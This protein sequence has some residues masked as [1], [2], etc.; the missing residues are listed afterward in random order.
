[1]KVNDILRKGEIALRVLLMKDDLCFCIN[2]NSNFMPVWMP[3]STLNEYTPDTAPMIDTNMTTKQKQVAHERYTMIA[4]MLALI[5]DEESDPIDGS[6]VND[7]MER[8]SQET[9]ALL[10]HTDKQT[11]MK[12]TQALLPEGTYQ[13]IF[14]VPDAYDCLRECWKKAKEACITAELTKDD[15][16]WYRLY[17]EVN[18][19]N[20]ND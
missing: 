1:M 6:A 2:C 11:L 14:M 20:S 13:D 15:L 18:A 4:P 9:D 5:N 19:E 17:Q 16:S 7:Y 8:L 3:M 10:E 12:W